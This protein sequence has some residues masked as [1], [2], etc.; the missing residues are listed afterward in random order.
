[1]SM[2]TMLIVWI[3]I[4]IGVIICIVCKAGGRLQRKDSNKSDIIC[5]SF[6]QKSTWIMLLLV[7]AIFTIH[8]A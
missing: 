7:I 5:Y 8:L 1:M 6:D 3:I 4:A 2:E